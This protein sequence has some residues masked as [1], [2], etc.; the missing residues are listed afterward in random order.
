[1]IFP[2][3]KDEKPGGSASLLDPRGSF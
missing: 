3:V 1:M 2:D